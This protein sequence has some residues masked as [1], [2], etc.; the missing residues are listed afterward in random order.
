[1]S[2]DLYTL[3]VG[4]DIAAESASIAY[5]EDPQ[6]PGPVFDIKQTQ[7]GIEYL[8]KRL[9]ATKH[10]P[11][12]TLVVVE[13]TGNYWWKIALALHEAGYRVSVINP[14]RAHYFARA[15]LKRAKTDHLDAQVLAQ[16]AATLKPK[17]WTP[18]PEVHGRLLQRLAQRED[19]VKSRTQALNRLH[20]LRHLPRAEE[21]VI[22][23]QKELAD[24]LQKQIT[25]I[26]SELEKV[27][28]SD[29][30]WNET[31]RLLL[32]VKGIGILTAA[33]LLVVTCNFTSCDTPGQLVSYAGLAPRVRES[34]TSV[35]GRRFIGHAGSNLLRKTLFMAALNATQHNPLIQTFY[36]R[37]RDRGKSF[38][39]ANCACARK[40]LCIC[41]A[42]ATKKTQFDPFYQPQA[43][44]VPAIA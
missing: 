23:R 15:L 10:P 1:M 5:T 38:K 2:E 35:N 25:E 33:W 26:D 24:F 17:L 6:T 4:I 20:A 29:D 11:D 30:E 28:E 27:L 12:K 43:E 21:A 40:L 22:R 8:K 31:A 42:V 34:G 9:L 7:K 36:K 16:L 39:V 32:G 37:L 13:A 19:L 44:L 3:F 14:A 18:P 41:W